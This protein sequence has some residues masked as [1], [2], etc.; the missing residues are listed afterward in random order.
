MK[1][2]DLYL[3]IGSILIAIGLI[4]GLFWKEFLPLMGFGLFIGMFGVFDE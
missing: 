1:R 4:Y 3:G 2:K